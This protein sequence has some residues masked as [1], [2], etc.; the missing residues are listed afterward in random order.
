MGATWYTLSVN[1]K[2]QK[3]TDT[4]G[5]E[6]EIQSKSSKQRKRRII[7]RLVNEENIST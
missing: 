2:T 5:S 4:K 6:K 7:L 1:K 3:P